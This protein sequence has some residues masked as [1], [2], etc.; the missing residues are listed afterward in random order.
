MTSI[1]NQA[2]VEILA[3]ALLLGACA[4]EAGCPSGSHDERGACISDEQGHRIKASNA[5]SGDYFG[6]RVALSGDTLVVGAY[7]EASSTTGVNGDQSNNDAE[8][9]GAVYV[10]M[11]SGSRWIQQAY[12]KASNAEARDYFGSSV[13]ISGDTLVVGAYGESSNATGVNGDQSDNGGNYNGA[14]YVFVRNGAVWFQQAYLKASNSAANNDFGIS[15]AVSGDTVVVGAYLE[16]GSATGINGSQAENFAESSGAAYVFARNDG[17]WTQQAYLK[18]SNAGAYDHFGASVALA[19]E[20]LVVGAYGEGSNATNING[21]QDNNRATDSGAAY[22]FVR[23]GDTWTQEAYLKASNARAY[24]E[25]GANVAISGDT[26]VVGA[27]AQDSAA[28]EISASDDRTDAIDSGAVYVFQ[29]S[30][31]S[32]KQQAYLKASS[33]HQYDEFGASVAVSGD[34]LVAGAPFVGNTATGATDT[35]AAYW[36]TRSGNTWAEAGYLKS[37]NSRVYDQFGTSVSVSDGTFAVGAYGENSA[38]TG[39]SGVQ[40]NNTTTDSGSVYMFR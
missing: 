38:A 10:F 32:W 16:D 17:L 6:Y 2:R 40:D 29:R 26:V 39:N 8:G 25:F 36:F 3:C 35:G 4:A 33:A 23:V 9:S 28:S 21:D 27:S 30:D 13:A 20:T 5:E 31:G 24:D 11:R 37:S 18:A 22:V 1:E 34:V 7:G 12:L 19:G 14:A 15:V